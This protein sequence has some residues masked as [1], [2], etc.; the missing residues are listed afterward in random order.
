MPWKSRWTVDI[1]ALDVPSY[2]FGSQTEPLGDRPL[3]IDADKPEYH[4]TKDAL[5]LW[6]KRF[7]LGLHNHGFQPGDRLLL[8]SG[9]TV[10]FPVVFLGTMMAE[11]VFSGANP[12]YV[13]R[14]LAYQM[15]DTGARFLITNEA[16]LDTSLEAARSIGF[17]EDRIFVFDPCYDTFDGKG[18]S[19][20]GI[21][22]WST[23]MASP[24][25]AQNF[26]WKT[27]TSPKDLEQTVAL[28]YSSGT[29]GV[30]K[31]VMIS[32]RA[33]V[34]NTAQVV[35]QSKLSAD[36]D[37]KLAKA[38]WL[39]ML[40][41]YHAYG[42]TYFC[43]TGVQLGVPT[44]IMKK[45]DF[46]KMLDHIQKFRISTLNLVPPIAVALAKRPE[47]KD[48]DLSSVESVGSG[49]APLGAEPA[50]LLEG[51]WPEGKV[52]VKQG[53]GM[54]EVTCSMTTWH[55]DDVSKGNSIGELLP[56]C[57]AMIVD[58]N[59]DKEVPRGQRG[60]F[61][62]RGPTLMTGY[63]KKPEATADTMKDGWLM[64]GD[65]AYLDEEGKIFIVDRKK[66]LIKVKGNQVAPA[67]LEGLLLDLDDISDA[68]VVGI[69]ING[70]ELPRA[71]VVKSPDSKM[72]PQDVKKWMDS[73]VARHK[74]LEGGVVF[75]DEIPKNPVGLDTLVLK[76]VN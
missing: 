8:F 35:Y 31:G 51:R 50:K 36:F 10:F 43:C 68:A 20:K 5:R 33:Y 64:T 22:H 1:P 56:N 55:P 32:H 26:K 63:W 53:W 46:M 38:A 41:M 72:S 30:P 25:E 49:A 7:A 52:N 62:V 28:N 12:T 54:T 3:I 34:A 14:E 59:G 65:I 48:F 60:E 57:E 37:E 6:C 67:E 69:T 75:V 74:R 21:K 44:Y 40:P 73:R 23:L 15:D 17:P 42:Q 19:V 61:W 11:G 9:N 29:T 24:S 16:S 45:F 66:E 2:V 71:Y 70:D 58:E 18:K 27:L 13:A 47:V 39:G 76:S 4:L